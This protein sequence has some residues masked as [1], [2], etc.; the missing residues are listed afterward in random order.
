MTSWRESARLE[1]AHVKLHDGYLD[2]SRNLG[3]C[4]SPAAISPLAWWPYH[5]SLLSPGCLEARLIV[6]QECPRRHCQHECTCVIRQSKVL[7]GMFE[8]RD[9]GVPTCGGPCPPLLSAARAPIGILIFD[10]S[11]IDSHLG[12]V[13]P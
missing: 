2:F 3:V 7:H 11:W 8:L 5:I 9:D 6:L 12:T 4:L 10:G 13:S 1:L